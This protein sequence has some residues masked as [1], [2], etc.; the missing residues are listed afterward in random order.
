MPRKVGC[1]KSVIRLSIKSLSLCHYSFKSQR[2][3]KSKEEQLTEKLKVIKLK[4]QSEKAKS[5]SLENRP[6]TSEKQAK[7][8]KAAC[9]E[10][11]N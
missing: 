2:I 8:L 4:L 10:L 3:M 5:K 6:V 9:L 7:A 1:P 11:K